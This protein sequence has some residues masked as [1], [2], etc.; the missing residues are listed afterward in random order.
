[1]MIWDRMQAAREVM[2]EVLTRE[3]F[4]ERFVLEPIEELYKLYR[5]DGIKVIAFHYSEYLDDRFEEILDDIKEQD[6]KRFG[7]DDEYWHDVKYWMLQHFMD[8]VDTRE[9]AQELLEKYLDE[10]TSS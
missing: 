3:A 4:I 7:R 9:L 2:T 10:V 6:A 5:K 8:E 1:M